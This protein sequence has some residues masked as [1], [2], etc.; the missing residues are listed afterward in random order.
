M[1]QLIKYISLITLSVLILAPVSR[2]QKTSFT[3]TIVYDV[4]PGQDLPEFTK[5][6]A[7]KMMTYKFS[8]DKQLMKLSFPSMEQV[9]IYDPSAKVARILMDIFGQKIVVNQSAAEIEELRKQQGEIKGIKET[10][11]TKTIAGY[12]C[13]QAVITRKT[14][15]GK[16]VTSTIYYTDAI[17]VSKFSSFSTFPEI[18]GVPLEFSMKTGQMDFMVTARSV[19]KESVPPSEFV[20]GS[21]YRQVTV[22]E[23]RKMFGNSLFPGK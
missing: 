18:K 16:E 12:P 17:D 11:E 1:K 5:S 8:N 13:K 6:M 15:E 22:E 20:V 4:K 2:A 3:G 19:S 9:T 7:P 23:L 10:N 14:S 21:D